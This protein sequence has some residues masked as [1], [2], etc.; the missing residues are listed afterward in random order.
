MGTQCIC[1]LYANVHSA[2]QGLANYYCTAISQVY[3]REGRGRLTSTQTHMEGE[4]KSEQEEA[5]GRRKEERR[6]ETRR[7]ESPKTLPVQTRYI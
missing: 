2:C 4:N 5:K 7:R 3:G 1:Y 6:R